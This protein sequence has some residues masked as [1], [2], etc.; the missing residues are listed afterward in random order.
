MQEYTVSEPPKIIIYKKGLKCEIEYHTESV[1]FHA[2]IRIS[3]CA[4]C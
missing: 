1:C 2:Q 3:Q 4:L